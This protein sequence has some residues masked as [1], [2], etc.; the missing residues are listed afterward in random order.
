MNTAVVPE[1]S[2]RCATVIAVSGSAP[3]LSFA[4]AASF[5]LVILPRKLAESVSGVSYSSLIDGSL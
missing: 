1:P 3:G 2:E 4:I 5:H